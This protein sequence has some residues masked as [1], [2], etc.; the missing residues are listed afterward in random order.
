M[1]A[2]LLLSTNAVYM[3]DNNAYIGIGLEYISCVSMVSTTSNLTCMA[4]LCRDT[5]DQ[6]LIMK[7]IAASR[8][9]IQKACNMT[10]K[11]TIP[12]PIAVHVQQTPT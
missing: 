5:N 8:H 10:A 1:Y 7:E 3:A 9:A 2:Q 6:K 12:G 4:K 11:K